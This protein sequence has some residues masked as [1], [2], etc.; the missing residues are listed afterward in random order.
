MSLTASPFAKSIV[1]PWFTMPRCGR[2]DRVR[3]Y[4]LMSAAKTARHCQ[5]NFG[6]TPPTEAIAAALRKAGPQVMPGLI[7]D[8][9]RRGGK[10]TARQVGRSA[11][12]R[13]S[14]LTER[15]RDAN[16]RRRLK[17]SVENS[18]GWQDWVQV[19]HKDFEEFL[20]SLPDKSVDLILTDPEWSKFKKNYAVTLGREANRVLKPNGYLAVMAGVLTMP[21][22][23][24]GVREGKMKYRWTIGYFYD[25]RSAELELLNIPRSGWKPV[26]VFGATKRRIEKDVVNLTK[27]GN[28]FPRNLRSEKMTLD[29]SQACAA[30]EDLFKPDKECHRWGQNFW[31][32]ERLVRLLSRPGE[33]VVDCFCGSGTTL[34]A[35]LFAA[36]GPRR[37][38]GCDLNPNYADLTRLDCRMIYDSITDLGSANR[39]AILRGV[40]G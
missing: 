31:G 11:R 28:V 29:Q 10:E 19:E 12:N 23:I 33:V 24:D 38:K 8:C 25:P 18:Q 37:V 6:Y 7:E 20:K 15:E 36:D 21:D 32:F 22:W 4:Q 5:T 13:L 9:L 2:K 14:I 26:L 40:V 39:D 17:E 16:L 27:A 30:G 1:M 34:K 3:G 35:A